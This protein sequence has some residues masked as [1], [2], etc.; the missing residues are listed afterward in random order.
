MARINGVEI[1]LRAN[2]GMR[3]EARRYRQW[4]ADGRQ[5]GTSVARDKARQ[6]LSGQDIPADW[7][8]EMSA[9]F[10]RHEVDKQGQGFRQGDEG[11]PSPGRVAWAAWGGDA[12]QAW[13]NRKA[14]QIKKAR[15]MAD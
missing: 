3:V 14:E 12:G 7:V 1:D 15:E 11:Y 8:I 2:E 6:I 13:S 5:G 10:A 9:W 4:K